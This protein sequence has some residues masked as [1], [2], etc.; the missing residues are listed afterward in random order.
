MRIKGIILSI[1]LVSLLIF[2]SVSLSYDENR[3]IVGVSP[4][5]HAGIM[6]VAGE[7]LSKEGYTVE[8]MEFYDYVMPNL[9]LSD[10][11]IDANF[12]QHI[13]YLDDQIAGMRYRLTWLAK[14]HIE[15]MGLYSTKDK[16]VKEIANGTIVAVPSAPT[17][18]TRALRLL[19]GA[20]IIKVN[21]KIMLTR[22]DIIDNPKNLRFLELSSQQIPGYLDKVEAAVINAN[23]ALEAGL[24]PSKNALALDEGAVPYSNVLVVRKGD[25]NRPALRAL[26]AALNSPE[27]RKYIATQLVPMGIIPAF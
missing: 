18:F 21:N 19:E 15:P 22:S 23:V 12:S 24:I 7:L 17:E 2:P 8:I 25:E 10:G 16:S 27:V 20:G 26:A 13:A 6:K 11:S 3:I 14:V 4:I 5:P 9:A 1:T